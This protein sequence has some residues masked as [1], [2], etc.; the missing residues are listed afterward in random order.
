MPTPFV[1]QN[2]PYLIYYNTTLTGYTRTGTA[3]QT[4]VPANCFAD[5]RR[6]SG[7][8]I[9]EK[10]LIFH[11]PCVLLADGSKGCFPVTI[12][13]AIAFE[14]GMV[15]TLK[16]DLPGIL[17]QAIPDLIVIVSI[18]YVPPCRRD[19]TQILRREKAGQK[20]RLYRDLLDAEPAG[21]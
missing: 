7:V 8:F 3:V 11:L 4:T 15:S 12:L 21:A 19:K 1:P 17:R 14:I 16:N 6:I 13:K 10:S 20:L 18:Q 9:P 5:I 2:P